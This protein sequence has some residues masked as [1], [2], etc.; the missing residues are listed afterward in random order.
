MLIVILGQFGIIQNIQ[1]SPIPLTSFLLRTFF[2]ASSSKI[3]LVHPLNSF[4]M[5][6][7][8]CCFTNSVHNL[9]KLF[10]FLKF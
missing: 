3:T 8:T 5:L 2:A 6:L 9:A 1:T 4:P 7:T 10:K